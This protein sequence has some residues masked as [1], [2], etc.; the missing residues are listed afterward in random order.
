MNNKG[1]TFIEILAV[2]VLIGILSSI[3]IIGV[4]RYREN[5]KNKDYE[6]LARSSYNAMEEYMIKNPYKKKASLETLE[7][8]SFL[9][10]RKD[11]GTKTTDCTGSVEVETEEDGSNGTMDKNK[12]TVYLCCTNY[13]KKYTYPKGDVEP[14]NGTDK[15]DIDESSTEP[16]PIPTPEPTPGQTTTQVTFNC[17]GG[18]GGG[19]QS[20]TT[21]V[22]NQKFNQT[23]SRNGYTL[24]GWKTNKNSTSKD[25]EKNY[26][27]TDNW[28]K[29]NS[30]SKTLYAHWIAT[31]YT[32]KY[33]LN[34]ASDPG[35]KTNYTIETSTF[36]LKNPTLKDYTFVG[37]T[38]SNGSDNEKTV[39]IAKGSTGNKSY[40]AH[41][42]KEESLF[43]YYIRYKQKN[44]TL[45]NT[46][47]NN[48]SSKY[49]GKPYRKYY[50]KSYECTCI[51]DSNKKYIKTKNVNP[52]E[53][54]THPDNDMTVFYHNTNHGKY[55]C[56][57]SHNHYVNQN[58]LTICIDSGFD[59]GSKVQEGYHGYVWYKNNEGADAKYHSHRNDGWY[60]AQTNY[61]DRYKPTTIE[62]TVSERKKACTASCK[63]VFK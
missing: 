50:Y 54:N 15:C 43:I 61:D 11:P 58:V 42:Q 27:V 34:G 25:Y 30:P 20:F 29:A 45:N 19:T 32:I 9:S 51:I 5:A 47:F 23:C 62:N 48:H 2:I 17:N 7:N 40:I 59:Y 35:N 24:D 44:C 63:G 6:A 39:R 55:S 46:D 33:T 31:K 49:R 60:H 22:Q 16:D 12:Y 52:P 56:E 28:I 57:K 36:T 10:N 38:G 41:F 26:N 3:A 14:Y 4:S 1:F 13:K 37:W 18:T 53:R 8:G 21:G